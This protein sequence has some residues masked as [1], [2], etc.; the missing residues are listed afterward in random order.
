MCRDREWMTAGTT[1]ILNC[2]GESWTNTYTLGFR[3]YHRQK[4]C[5]RL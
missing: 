3:L 1:A 5:S 2:T 4:W